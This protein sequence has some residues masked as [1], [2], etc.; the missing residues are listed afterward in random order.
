V[1]E[2]LWID[3]QSPAEVPPPAALAALTQAGRHVVLRFAAL[4]DSDKRELISRL[5]AALPDYS[6]FNSGGDHDR[7]WVTVMPVV[8]RSRVLERHGHIQRAIGEYR[9]ACADLVAKYEAGTL[10]PEW[11][12]DVHGSHCRFESRRTGQV[13]EAPLPEWVD[14]A[15]VDPYFFALF[16]RT[17]AG[18][19][20]V[21]ELLS[22]DFHDAARILDIVSDGGSP[23]AGPVAPA[24]RR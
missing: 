2:P 1:G 12:A 4:P 8:A 20:L 23:D 10:Q 5:A 24:D 21:S 17:T 15:P 14:P 7:T 16:V 6:V 13:V 22:H 3:C 18:L 19:E 11:Q 9:R